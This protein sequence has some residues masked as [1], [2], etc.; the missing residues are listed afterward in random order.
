MRIP[1]IHSS[2]RAFAISPAIHKASVSGSR[3]MADE[4]VKL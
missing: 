1:G 2:L 3:T 4:V